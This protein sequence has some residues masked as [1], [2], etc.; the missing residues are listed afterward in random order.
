VPTPPYPVNAQ[1]TRFL[2]P[3][4]HLNAIGS[5]VVA[6]IALLA[7]GAAVATPEPAAI[8]AKRAELARIQAE[9]ASIEGQVEQ[10]AEAYNGARYELGQVNE[11]ID[12]NVRQATQTQKDLVA[13]REV[14]AQ[15]LRSIYASPDPSLV[16]ILLN[17]GS[18]ATAADQME[19]L[20]RVGQQDAQ[21]VGGLRAQKARLAELKVQ[22]EKDRATAAEAV[23][24]RER[25][26]ARAE[27]LQAEHERVMNSASA[28][29]RQMIA[30][31]KERERREAE[32]QARLA[33]QRAA[34]ASA[35][36]TAA[37]ATSSGGGDSSSS[38]GSSGSAPSAPLP[39]G[40]GN[41]AAAS[42]AMQYLG[43]PYVWGGASPS[44]FDCSGLASYAYAQI[45]KSVPHYTG[46]IWA[47]FPKVPSDQLAPGDMVFFNGLGHMGIYIG[48]GQYVHAPHTGDVV[49]VSSLAGR[50]DYVGAVRP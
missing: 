24:A 2:R 50:S 21:V 14:L 45:G 20:D 38:G 40:S 49:K 3:S 19:L 16:E 33:Q 4:R 17:S 5:A 1:E 48:G 7:F 28:E 27:A 13:S 37:P 10:A 12:A 39:S 35:A 46:A 30:A 31:E 34:A 22:L 47:A 44:G 29:L 11:R 42:I 15:R 26:K 25:E 41:A 36:T 6:V 43:V 8:E 18:I 23:A 32:A 9:L